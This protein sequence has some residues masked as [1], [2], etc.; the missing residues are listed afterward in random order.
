MADTIIS[1]KKLYK[2]Y[3]FLGSR[4]SVPLSSL[5]PLITKQKSAIRIL[6]LESYN[7]H[8]E[9]LFKNLEILPLPLLIQLSNLKFLHSCLHNNAPSAFA[10]TWITSFEHRHNTNEPGLVYNLR[11][12]NNLFV[13]PSRLKSMSLFPLYNFPTL[14]NELPLHLRSIPTKTLFKSNLKYHYL[15]TLNSIP[16]CNRLFCPSCSSGAI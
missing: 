12:D 10:N 5:K 8:T 2:E 14:W 6:S 4:S 1:T 16:V 3:S 9:P 11:N 7:A 15:S 13:P